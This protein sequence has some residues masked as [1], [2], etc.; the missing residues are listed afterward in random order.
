MHF[1]KKDFLTSTS[2]I[3]LPSASMQSEEVF[4]FPTLVSLSSPQVCL[5]VI[6]ISRASPLA[7]EMLY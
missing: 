6:N 4:F 7:L 1:Q 5:D 3:L 2:L